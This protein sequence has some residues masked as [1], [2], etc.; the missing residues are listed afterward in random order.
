[1]LPSLKIRMTFMYDF[2]DIGKTTLLGRTTIKDGLFLCFLR[3]HIFRSHIF[4][5]RF[6]R[7]FQVEN[8]AASQKCG[9]N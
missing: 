5:S 2:I 9:Q 6:G 1:M 8:I 3:R 4:L 7:W